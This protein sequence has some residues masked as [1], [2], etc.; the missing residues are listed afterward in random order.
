MSPRSAQQ[1][2]KGIRLGRISS[3]LVERE[4]GYWVS[5]RRASINYPREGNELCARLES[6]S[7]WFRHR[8]RCILTAV[9]QLPPR[10]TI[11]DV[12][13]GNGHVALALESAGVSTVLIEPGPGAETARSRGLSKVARSTLEDAAFH[14]G[15]LDAVGLFDVL[16][17][18][19]DD[20]GMLRTLHG[21]LVP[22]G[23]LYLT[24]PA[25]RLLWSAEDDFAQHV[26]RYR[27]NELRTKLL[28]SG[29]TVL[30]ATYF[31]ALLPLPILLFRTIP[32]RLGLRQG[33]SSGKLIAREHGSSNP[34]TGRMAAALLRLE[35]Q[36]LAG[37]HD[38]PFG[39]SC[40]VIAQRVCHL[41]SAAPRDP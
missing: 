14:R 15:T 33:V 5:H 1:T 34:W 19:E 12:G 10:G 35:D 6:S 30:R 28:E 37:G 26:R 7:F 32:S 9:R 13:G 8:N 22:E 36:W 20:H 4:P 3:G 31:F 18:V 29:F 25:Y 40:L 38:L 21:L 24:V 41:E 16:E 39:A 11:Y 2:G 27:L 17:H 23:R